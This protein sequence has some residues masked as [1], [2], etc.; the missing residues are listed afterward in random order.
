MAKIPFNVKFRPQ[1]ESGKYKVILDCGVEAEILAWDK[2]GEYPIVCMAKKDGAIPFRTDNNGIAYHYPEGSNYSD[3]FIVTP[4]PELTEFEKAIEEYIKCFT[5]IVQT[6][7]AAK[8]WSAE[9]LN[10]ARKEIVDKCDKEQE[11]IVPEDFTKT[12][13]KE[14]FL[15][16]ITAKRLTKKLYA[17]AR[18]ELQ[19]EIDEKIRVIRGEEYTRGYH[20]GKTEALK[21]LPRWK[22]CGPNTGQIILYKGFCKGQNYLDVGGYRIMLSD[23]EKLPKEDE[24]HE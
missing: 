22:K 18:K 16:E 20:D 14:A 12:L 4:E 11:I 6:D 7:V 23:L 1:I 10:I 2:P 24:D 17:I 9:L 21:D 3:L 15:D 8:Q 13:K 19:S 5:G